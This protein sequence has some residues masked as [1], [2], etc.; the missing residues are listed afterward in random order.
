MKL[1]FAALLVLISGAI[2]IG[3]LTDDTT[4]PIATTNIPTQARPPFEPAPHEV[5]LERDDSYAG[6]KRDTVYVILEDTGE[7]HKTLNYLRDQYRQN[8]DEVTIFGFLPEEADAI[9]EGTNGAYTVGVAEG[10]NCQ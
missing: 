5:I 9:R 1:L 10:G 7:A 2:L 4:E 3:S 6:C 8:A